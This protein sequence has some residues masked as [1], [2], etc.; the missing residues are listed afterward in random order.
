MESGGRVTEDD[1]E[2]RARY[3]AHLS[4]LKWYA[5]KCRL[6]EERGAQC[7]RCGRN[8]PLALHHKT[9][10]RLGDELPS[11]VE[12]LCHECHET[13]DAERVA[14]SHNAALDTYATKKYGED[15]D[16][17]LDPEEV[18]DEFDEWLERKRE[19]F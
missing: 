2:W 17:D 11:D 13:A 15:W 18:A 5:L 3:E 4:S 6:I 16:L 8:L 14:A 7:E 12:L 1:D 9:Y 10:E 19:D